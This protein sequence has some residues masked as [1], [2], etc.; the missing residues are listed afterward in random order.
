MAGS[1]QADALK[2]DRNNKLEIENKFR[3]FR[4]GY[5]L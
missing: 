1:Y 4:W 3:R 2:G 5:V